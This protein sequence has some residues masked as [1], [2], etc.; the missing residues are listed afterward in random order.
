MKL[1]VNSTKIIVNPDKEIVENI[2]K[3]LKENEGYCPCR[4]KKTPDTKCICKEFLAQEEGECHCGLYI[5]VK[6]E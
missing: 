1:N 4:L 2:R 3:R 5:K 6:G